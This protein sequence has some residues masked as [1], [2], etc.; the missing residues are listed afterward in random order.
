MYLGVLRNDWCFEFYSIDRQHVMSIARGM[1]ICVYV[2]I[3]ISIYVSIYLCIYDCISN[4]YVSM[5]LCIY[6]SIGPLDDVTDSYRKS[7]WNIGIYLYMNLSI[8]LS[9]YLIHYLILYL[10]PIY[11]S[12]YQ[13]ISLC[14]Y[15]S[16]YLSLYVSIG[17][18]STSIKAD[19][20]KTSNP[21]YIYLSIDLSLY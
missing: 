1:Y 12:L 9:I 19:K 16:M 13:S 6:V 7:A 5:C 15:L 11:L 3:S 14:I 4:L 17:K 18:C 10:I 21:R 8:H 20:K 2:S